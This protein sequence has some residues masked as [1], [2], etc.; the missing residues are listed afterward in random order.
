M[1]ETWCEMPVLIQ[2]GLDLPPAITHR[3]DYTEFEK[4]FEVMISGK[5]GKV[6]LNWQ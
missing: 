5:S 2:G 1:Y 6:I 3:F 4:G